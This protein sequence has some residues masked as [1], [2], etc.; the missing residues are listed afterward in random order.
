MQVGGWAHM[1][2]HQISI[3]PYTG[4]DAWG[5]YTYGAAQTYRARVQGRTRVVTNVR[6]EEVVSKITV[7][8]AA[9]G[10]ITAQD[11]LTLPSPWS[12]TQPPILDVQYVSNDVGHHHMVILA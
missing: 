1:M 3:E 7:Y 9:T 6:G 10:G 2:P 8:V 11:R 12:P 5:A 4:V